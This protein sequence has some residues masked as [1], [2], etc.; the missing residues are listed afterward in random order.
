M[1]LEEKYQLER[2][3]IRLK[4]WKMFK[5]LFDEIKMEKIKYMKSK[6]QVMERYDDFENPELLLENI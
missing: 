5:I 3:K 6:N 2:E 1:N 4:Y